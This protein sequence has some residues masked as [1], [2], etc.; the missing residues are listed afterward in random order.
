MFLSNPKGLTLLLSSFFFFT[1]I[2]FSNSHTTVNSLSGTYVTCN[3]S[4]SSL[5]STGVADKVIKWVW[6]TCRLH[7]TVTILKMSDPQVNCGSHKYTAFSTCSYDS[8]R[9][10][11]KP[12][13]QKENSAAVSD[14]QYFFVCML[15]MKWRY[16][17]RDTNLHEYFTK[18]SQKNYKIQIKTN[19]GKLWYKAHFPDAE[20][21]NCQIYFNYITTTITTTSDIGFP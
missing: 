4:P 15:E 19:K 1:N 11:T 20:L 2:Y 3:W 17:N 9:C 14:I 16:Q 10:I 12:C 7:I 5:S 8:I 18:H 13:L 21:F 6:I